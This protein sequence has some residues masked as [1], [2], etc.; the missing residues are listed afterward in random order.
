M[1]LDVT[2]SATA[3]VTVLVIY[4]CNS[5]MSIH[6]IIARYYAIMPRQAKGI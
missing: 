5:G 1:L 3:Y 6:K 4:C 2:L